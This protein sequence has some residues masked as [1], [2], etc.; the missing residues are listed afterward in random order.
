MLTKSFLL[1]LQMNRRESIE[2]SKGGSGSGGS[3]S[4]ERRRINNLRRSR[5]WDPAYTSTWITMGLSF[6]PK[7]PPV[8]SSE[9]YHFSRVQSGICT[10]WG[11][12]EVFLQNG[13]AFT[14]FVLPHGGAIESASPEGQWYDLSDITRQEHM[15]WLLGFICLAVELNLTLWHGAPTCIEELANGE[16]FLILNVTCAFQHPRTSSSQSQAQRRRGMVS[17][18]YQSLDSYVTSEEVRLYHQHGKR[19]ML[20]SSKF[21]LQ[22]RSFY[23]TIP[24]E[25][26]I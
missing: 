15:S 3:G 17:F 11:S 5:S 1:L 9:S 6:Y 12:R 2:S 20:V 10:Q 26:V 24:A 19:M 8:V 7:P 4:A 22:F 14:L 18:I 16:T 13:L 21:M 25:F 23:H